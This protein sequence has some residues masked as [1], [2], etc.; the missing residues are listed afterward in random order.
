MKSENQ[1]NLLILSL[2]NEERG[3]KDNG[4]KKSITLL[5]LFLLYMPLYAQYTGNLP[6]LGHRMIMIGL[7]MAKF[8]KLIMEVLFLK[9]GLCGL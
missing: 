6:S 9:I 3:Q 8:L 7:Q 5:L 4:L 1:C 2:G